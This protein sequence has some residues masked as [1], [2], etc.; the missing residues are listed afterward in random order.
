M[1]IYFVVILAFRETPS[2]RNTLGV[3]GSLNACFNFFKVARRNKGY[4][5]FP[6]LVWQLI[7]AFD[8]IPNT[9][10]FTFYVNVFQTIGK[11]TGIKT[12]IC[13]KT[14]LSDRWSFKCSL[15]MY[16]LRKRCAGLVSVWCLLPL[17]W[18]LSLYLATHTLQGLL[19]VLFSV[20]KG[21]RTLFTWCRSGIVKSWM[22]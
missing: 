11:K 15:W 20:C 6:N 14:L 4:K 7:Y 2:E 16:E 10:S 5:G 21:H 19:N 8:T 9:S 12:S 1:M 22:G 3:W 17:M 18:I 13:F